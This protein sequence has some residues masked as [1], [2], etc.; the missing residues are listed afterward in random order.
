MKKL[1][2]IALTLLLGTTAFAQPSRKIGPMKAGKSDIIL[3]QPE[4]ELHTYIRSGGCCDVIYRGFFDDLSQDGISAQV[5]ISPDGKTAY[6]KNII[7]RA[8]TGAWVKGTIKNNKIQVPYGQL[9]YWFEDPKNTAGEP[10]PEYG[11]KLAGITMKGA[12]TS[13]EVNTTGN[14]VFRIEDD[15]SRLVLEGTSADL[16]SDNI[17]GLGL[18]YTN[19]YDGEWS[20][21]MDYETVYTEVEETPVTPP[22]GIT[23]ERYSI[24]HGI[25]GHFVDVAF[26]RDEVYIRGISDEYVPNAWIRGTLDAETNKITFPRQLAGSYQVY[27]FYFIGV[28][29]TKVD[30]SYGGQYEYTLDSNNTGIVF[31]YDPETRSFWN[32]DRALIVN[33]SKDAVDRFERFPKPMFRP[34][35]EKAATPAAPAVLELDDHFWAYGYNVSTLAISIPCM[36]EDGNFLDPSKLYYRLYVDDDEPYLLYQDEYEGLP[37]D[38]VDEIP[39]LYT[40]GK[41]IYPKSLGMYIYQNGFERMGIQSIYY[42]GDERHETGIYYA[43]PYTG[44][45][46]VNESQSSTDGTV[47][48]LSGRRIVSPLS[49]LHSSLK[50]GI[51]IINGKKV[52]R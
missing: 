19:Q 18:V 5:V 52:V 51:Y 24:T 49:S 34:Y 30:D 4:G 12:H 43:K 7:S 36:D 13:Y 9:Y 39:Y 45:K 41:S 44:I 35:V 28:D 46:L 26:A 15:W 33:N 40:N 38:E 6:F 21:Y 27:L 48:D 50:K 20:Y 3:T 42:G 32:N 37:F 17:V 23:T 14:A 16:E 8:A 2:L 11:M 22:D 47:F 31:D 10:E 29:I 1:L 25:Y